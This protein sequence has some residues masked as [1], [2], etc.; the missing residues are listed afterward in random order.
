VGLEELL[1][2]IDVALPVDPLIH[3]Q[4]RVPHSD[5]RQLSLIHACGRV[6]HSEAREDHID[7]DVELPQSLVRQMAE[8]IVPSKSPGS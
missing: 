2:R 5:G 8:F 6:L 4:L 7:L 3:L 1:K